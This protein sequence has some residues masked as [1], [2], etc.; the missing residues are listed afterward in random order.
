[1]I[2]MNNGAVKWTMKRGEYHT[3][4]PDA[5]TLW[6]TV[7]G[8]VK[9]TQTHNAVKSGRWT[10]SEKGASGALGQFREMSESIPSSQLSAATHPT[11][12]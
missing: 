7:L 1:M 9:H 5:N 12:Q 10:N 4:Y 11:W 2:T 8:A 6:L 3:M